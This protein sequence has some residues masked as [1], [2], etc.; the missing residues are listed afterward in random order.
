MEIILH[1]ANNVG[2]WIKASNNGWGIEVDLRTH[3]GLVYLSHEPIEDDS[4]MEFSPSFS[5]LYEATQGWSNTVVLDSK[6]TGILKNLRGIRLGI[7]THYAFTDLVTPDQIFIRDS[8]GRTLTRKSKFE[9]ISI[10]PRPGASINTNQLEEYWLD[11]VFTPDDL[12]EFASVAKDSYVVSPELHK[13]QSKPCMPH[14]I[15]GKIIDLEELEQLK[16]CNLT[17]D[18]IKAVYDIGFKGVCTH[19]PERYASHA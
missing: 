17:D 4:W 7:D 1:R 13:Y 18:F 10:G 19:E 8:G 16:A 14:R 2:Q 11:Y 12:L 6:E 3:N 15:G 5:M 9:N